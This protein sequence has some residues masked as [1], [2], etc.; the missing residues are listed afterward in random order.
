[1]R[2]KIMSQAIDDLRH[3]HDAIPLHALKAKY[4]H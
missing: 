4:L 3:E 1:L 2:E